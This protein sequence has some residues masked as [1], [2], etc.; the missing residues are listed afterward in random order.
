MTYQIQFSP[1]SARQL[2]KLDGRTQRR[3]QAVVS[4][5]LRSP[6]QL[7]PRSSL[8]GMVN[9]VCAPATTASFTKSMMESW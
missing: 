6:A 5:L 2:R 9:G 3:I 7:A 8:E 1:A 4:C